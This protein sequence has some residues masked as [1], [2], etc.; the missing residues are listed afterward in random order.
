MTFQGCRPPPLGCETNARQESMK[1]GSGLSRYE[2]MNKLLSFHNDPKI[3][4]KYITRLKA[5]TKADE[6]IK[7]TYWENGKGCAVGCTV[8]SDNHNAYETELGLP[9]WLARLED[10]I[11]EAL[12]NSKAM[13]F[14]LLF[15]ESIPV[16]VDVSSV[17]DK[18]LAWLMD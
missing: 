3:K 4:A 12:P 16:G 15:L 10:G 2:F 6:I 5:H 9:S 11:F 1:A 8:H 17:R 7:G 13:K 14:P 18:F